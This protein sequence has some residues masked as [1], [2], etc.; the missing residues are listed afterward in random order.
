MISNSL[1]LIVTAVNRANADSQTNR[2]TCITMLV[3]PSKLSRLILGESF[4]SQGFVNW[5]FSEVL[6]HVTIMSED[7]FE[8]VHDK[9]HI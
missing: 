8:D 1:D 7:S 3:E 2:S 6:K 9:V 5:A 4:F